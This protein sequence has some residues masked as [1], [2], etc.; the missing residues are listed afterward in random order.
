MRSAER[1]NRRST[2]CA[3]GPCWSGTEEVSDCHLASRPDG[4]LSRMAGLKLAGAEFLGGLRDTRGRLL[5]MGIDNVYNLPSGAT[6]RNTNRG[7]KEPAFYEG[8]IG[9]DY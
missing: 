7:C 9:A 6:G 4:A 2:A 8:T 1:N 3:T 5:L